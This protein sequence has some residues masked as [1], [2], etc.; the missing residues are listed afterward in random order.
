MNVLLYACFERITP[1]AIVNTIA[2]EKQ[3]KMKYAW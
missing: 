1:R 2:F 3:N